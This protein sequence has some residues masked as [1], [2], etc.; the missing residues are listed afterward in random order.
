MGSY[1]CN[2][3]I[4]QAQELG[5]GKMIVLDITFYYRL[6]FSI[7]NFFKICRIPNQDR[8][9]PSGPL[10]EFGLNLFSPKYCQVYGSVLRQKNNV[11]WEREICAGKKVSSKII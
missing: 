2:Y 4:Q 8:K 5:L 9:N 3:G 11:D 1:H 6:P 10:K 7:I